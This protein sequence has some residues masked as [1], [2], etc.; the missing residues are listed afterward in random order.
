MFNM[1]AANIAKRVFDRLNEPRVTPN[2][3]LSH[4]FLICRIDNGFL[5]RS[6][7]S[8]L[9]G[10]NEQIM[11][12]KELADISPTLVTMM[13]ADKVLGRQSSKLSISDE[14]SGVAKVSNSI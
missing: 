11:Y 8:L 2:T 5:I 3:G 7:S 14:W 1:L 12:C 6:Q 4:G 9:G 13:A 10:H